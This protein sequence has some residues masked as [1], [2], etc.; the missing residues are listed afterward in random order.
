MAFINDLEIAK[1]QDTLTTRKAA[2]EII[3][4]FLPML[5]NS[6]SNIPHSDAYNRRAGRVAASLLPEGFECWT[7]LSFDDLAAEA[8]AGNLNNAS[9]AIEVLAKETAKP[10]VFSSQF[11][12]FALASVIGRPIF[13]VYPDIPDSIAIEKAL[14]GVCN[15]RQRFQEDD[16]L[17]TGDPV[18]IMWTRV[19]HSQLQGWRPNHF[20]P[21]VP[22]S[23]YTD[24]SSFA[25][26]V[27]I[28]T[29]R[30]Q[31]FAFA[32]GDKSQREPTEKKQLKVSMKTFLNCSNQDPFLMNSSNS[33]LYLTKSIK[34]QQC[35]HQPLKSSNKQR[36]TFT[37][38][39]NPSDKFSVF[40]RPNQ[41]KKKRNPKKRSLPANN[42]S[43][44]RKYRLS[45]TRKEKGV[46]AVKNISRSEIQLDSA[47]NEKHL[48]YVAL[49]SVTGKLKENIDK[50]L[51]K[52]SD[53]GSEKQQQQHLE[54]MITLANFI[55]EDGPMVE[56][57]HLAAKYKAIKESAA[58]RISSK[59]LNVAQIYINGKAYILE[60]PGKEMLDLLACIKNI[61]NID[62]VRS[63]I[64]AK[65]DEV[66][67]DDDR[68]ICKYLDTKRDRDTLKAILTKLTSS[69]FMAKLANV[70]DKHSFQHAKDQVSMN[71]Q[72]FK[73][74]KNEVDEC[75]FSWRSRKRE[76]VST[77]EGR[78]RML[79]CEKF[80]DLAAIME[81][82]FGESDHIKTGGG[83][84]ESHPRLT[85]FYIVLQ[86]AIRSCEMHE[87]L[88]W[89]W[90]QRNLTLAYLP[91][92][93]THKIIK[94]AH[95]KQN[96]ITPEKG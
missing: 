24:S 91:V 90:H 11:H 28:G 53:A 74:M 75:R 48:K 58:K 25:K 66:I 40:S 4:N 13:S 1:L 52:L 30:M 54:A 39:D 51:Q 61:N 44:T 94:K 42:E 84:L 69:T 86:T 87:K 37:I 71:I 35:P 59:H 18:H 64:K 73:G 65:V 27:K 32:K 57:Q 80:P 70:Q 45:L 17:G 2:H 19:T 33:Q 68:V 26:V 16:S 12:I 41:M 43:T 89:H 55:I 79:K 77:F 46:I 88:F 14:H 23:T 81:Y 50:L 78:G 92:L 9:R 95:I 8:Y 72:L 76:E 85:P 83:G 10:Y 56:T 34:R 22:F 29:K 31:H 67:G 47:S 63:I 6:F 82:S 15:P 5:R 62:D 49:G 38:K 20:T 7:P 93:I 21:I 96:V 60:N 36:G 3:E